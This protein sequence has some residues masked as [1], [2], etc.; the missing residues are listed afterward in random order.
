MDDRISQNEEFRPDPLISMIGFGA[1][2]HT[3]RGKEFIVHNHM[4]ARGTKVVGAALFGT[5]PSQKLSFNGYGEILILQHTFRRLA[6][7]HSTAVAKGPT[8]PCRSL[9]SNKTVF[10]PQEIGREGIFIKYMAVFPIKILITIIA[11]L[12]QTIFHPKGI[13]KII[14]KFML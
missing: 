12:Q 2:I 13:G 6:M 1:G 14:M 7:Q 11:D 10:N 4:G 8:F 5:V 3:M 9:F